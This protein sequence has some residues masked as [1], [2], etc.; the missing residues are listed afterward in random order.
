MYT[1]KITPEML[2]TKIETYFKR[3]GFSAEIQEKIRSR[4]GKKINNVTFRGR[5]RTDKEFDFRFNIPFD[6]TYR[7]R[8]SPQYKLADAELTSILADLH[9]AVK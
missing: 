2:K 8:I 6:G 7:P 3:K 4:T 9:S 5:F 1:E